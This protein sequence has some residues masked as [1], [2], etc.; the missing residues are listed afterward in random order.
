MAAGDVMFLHPAMVHSAGVNSSAH[1][2]G[3]LRMATIMEFQRARPAEGRHKRVL[4]WQRPG[5]RA[6]GRARPDGTFAPAADGRSPAEQA[7]DRVEVMWNMDAAEY[8]VP[9]RPRPADMWD[10]WSF[11][12][13]A[14]ERADVVIEAPWWERHGISLPHTIYQLQDIATLDEEGG[15]WR[16]D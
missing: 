4:W 5:D 2:G 3:T 13:D 12:A 6:G 11:S 8:M 10:R 7:E 9:Y 16:L 14:P 1:G 15:L